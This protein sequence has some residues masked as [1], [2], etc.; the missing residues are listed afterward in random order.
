MSA[1][2]RSRSRGPG[3]EQGPAEP[4]PA[5]S[6]LKRLYEI[7]KLLT[8]FEGVEETISAIVD[9]VAQTFV[10]R[11][12]IFILE[13]AGPRATAIWQA[14]GL[15][16]EGLRAA[17][18][19]ARD[20]YRYLVRSDLDLDQGET[21]TLPDRSLED[22]PESASSFVLIPIVVDHHPIFGAL[23]FECATAPSEEELVF[24][25]AVANQLAIALDRQAAIDARQATA[26]GRQVAAE[27]REAKTEAE[28]SWLKTVLDRMPSGVIIGNAPGGELLLVNRQA[29]QIL[30]HPLA[31]G[32]GG[33]GY[34]AFRGWHPQDGR[35]YEPEEWPLA[36]S[37]AKGE[38]VT[39]EEIDILRADGTRGTMIVSSAPI[40]VPDRGIVS[41]VAIFFDVTD[42]KQIE[43]AEQFLAE[44]SAVLAS[45][46]DYRTT[47]GRVVHLAI[48][49]LGELCFLDEVGEDGQIRRVEV[50]VEDPTKKGLADQLRH[51]PPR[52][53]SRMPQTEVIES[54]RSLL[55]S[56]LADP[57]RQ[58]TSEESDLLL[59][60]GFRSMI[61]VPL[62]A[63]GQYLGALTFAKTAT[64][65]AYSALDLGFAE[66]VAHR[67]ATAVDNGRLY[68]QAQTASRTRDDLMAVLSHDLRSPLSAIIGSAELLAQSVAPDDKR[69]K[70]VEAMRRSADWMQRLVE[71]LL[72]IARIEAGRLTLVTQ[73]CAVGALLSEVLELMQPLAQAK[74]LRLE[75]RISGP[76]F[77]FPCDRTRI[78]QVLCNLIG[79]SIKFSTQG[80]GISIGA[81]LVDGNVRFS[82]TDRGSGIAAE[83]LP[84]IFERFWQA[85]AV[86]RTGAG[87]GLA[88]ARGIVEAHGGTIWAESE[89]GKGSTFFFTVPFRR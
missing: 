64:G 63:R 83:E 32:S 71:D 75:R 46:L 61:V 84:H 50:A 34:A 59:A 36:R 35:P 20:S 79:N 87:L 3:P 11:S 15:S 51:L 78:L 48:P 77:D 82:V 13:G 52:P 49:L 45:S 57:A 25:N 65:G 73:S 29:E 69:L 7:S 14:A 47:V 4:A 81:E 58:T 88:I 37:I 39:D 85:R 62:S 53:G 28:R 40:E 26:Q 38:F 9:V 21:R 22:R 33:A 89:P 56:D 74:A 27:F 5:L 41:G 30:G 76:E 24:V 80:A 72:D 6:L 19:R 23:Q 10:L 67:A 68:R 86:A 43:R 66:V 17:K 54:G 1:E 12:V 70:W 42:R 16:E 2:R 18:S 8:S 31:L 44:A 55:I 60:A